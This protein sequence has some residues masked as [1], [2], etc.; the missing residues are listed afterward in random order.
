VT[1]HEDVLRVFH[2]AAA[3]PEPFRNVRAAAQQALDD[4]L[5]S[6]TVYALLVQL[7]RSDLSEVVLEQVA[8]VMD[9]VCGW[10][11]PNARMRKQ[12]QGQTE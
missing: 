1:E 3:S 7:H 2:L 8:D 10:C 9:L 6:D 5:S 11:A 12:S 4:D